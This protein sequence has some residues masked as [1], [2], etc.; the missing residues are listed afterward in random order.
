MQGLWKYVAGN[1]LKHFGT[2]K[3]TLK[4][5]V[6]ESF[7]ETPHWNDAF[8]IQECKWTLTYHIFYPN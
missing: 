8:V 3:I 7:T 2:L 6:K 4:N 5:N 1:Q